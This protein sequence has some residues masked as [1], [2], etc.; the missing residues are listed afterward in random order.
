MIS[1]EKSM[2]DGLTEE[3]N[4]LGAEFASIDIN[5]E[6]DGKKYALVVGLRYVGEVQQ[7]E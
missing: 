6:K 4:K 3:L 7:D 1:E 5:F 2:I